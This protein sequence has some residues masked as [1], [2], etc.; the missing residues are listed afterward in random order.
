MLATLLIACL[1]AIDS[2]STEDW[3]DPG[4][5]DA[6]KPVHDDEAEAGDTGAIELVRD[7]DDEELDADTGEVEDVDK[8]SCEVWVD[9][10][11]ADT[12]D[13][14]EPEPPEVVCGDLVTVGYDDEDGYTGDY[15]FVGYELS[16]G[17]WELV[18]D[19]FADGA[20]YDLYVLEELDGEYELVGWGTTAS[21]HEEVVLQLAS[22]AYVHVG[23]VGYGGPAGTWMLQVDAR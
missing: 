21:D 9:E 20:D 5:H 17:T 15:D 12:E 11:G 18:L 4:S 23:I 19:G 6:D 14:G 10:I 13:L 1:P 16:A 3:R 22:G 2:G 7:E 8:V